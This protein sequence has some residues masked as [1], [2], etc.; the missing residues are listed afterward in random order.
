MAEYL[1]A[2]L[3]NP[4]PDAFLVAVGDV[5]KAR[6]IS[7]VAENAGNSSAYSCLNV[8]HCCQ[9]PPIT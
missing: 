3:E 9:F 8:Q 7:K 5:A 4:E 2:A 1:A 6:G